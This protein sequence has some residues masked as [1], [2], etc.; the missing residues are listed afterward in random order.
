MAAEMIYAN[1]IH[2][3][4]Y[5]LILCRLSGSRHFW[6]AA[7]ARGDKNPI[8]LCSGTH[9][10]L[11]SE[12]NIARSKYISFISAGHFGGGPIVTFKLSISIFHS[13]SQAASRSTAACTG[14]FSFVQASNFALTMAHFPYSKC[15]PERRAPI[16]S[17][18]L[19]AR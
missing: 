14:S 12:H 9:T 17:V 6:L 2:I 16:A 4:I 18:L 8:K 10:E 13:Y 11:S 7:R 3:H 15:S 19:S 5:L 1:R